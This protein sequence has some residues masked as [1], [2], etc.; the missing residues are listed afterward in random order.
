MEIEA[1]EKANANHQT[2]GLCRRADVHMTSPSRVFAI[3][4]LF[5]RDRPIWTPD[6]IN[7]A[8][9]YS[10]P[11]GYRYVKELVNAGMLRKVSAGHYSLGGRII[12]LDYQ[13]RQTDPVLLAAMPA[14]QRLA[15][16][17]GFDAVLTVLFPGPR[18]VDIHRVDTDTALELAY[19]RG[20]PRP[21]FRSAAPKILLA[22]LPRAQLMKIFEGHASEIATAGLGKSWAEVRG[23]LADIRRQGY[24]RSEGELEPSLGAV[25]V[26]VFNAEGECVA[27]LALV[28]QIHQVGAQPDESLLRHLRGA[29]AEV[30]AALGGSGQQGSVGSRGAPETDVPAGMARARPSSQPSPA[31]GRG[32]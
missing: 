29:T 25:A 30:R 14:M 9:G 10:R 16:A 18:V 5:T 2:Q 3:L 20:R 31:R 32:R 6:E 23:A 21:V 19:G 4:D 13:L 17:S 7:D 26:P 28:G 11:T 12:E 1:C 27:A 8:L 22:H 24:Y 15:A